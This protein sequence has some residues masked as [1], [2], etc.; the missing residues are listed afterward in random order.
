M[1]FITSNGESRG[2]LARESPVPLTAQETR[3]LKRAERKIAA[4]LK[5]F[6]EVGMAL[7]EIR[8]KRLYRQHYR[9]FEEYVSQRWDI[10]RPRAYE[11]CA[12]SEVIADLSGVPDIPVLPQ[13]EAQ[14]N[15]LARLKT[16]THRKRAWRMALKSASQKS[17]PVTAKDTEEAVNE[18]SDKIDTSPVDGVPVL[19][20]VDGIRAAYADPPYVGQAKK[21]YRCEEVDHRELIERLETY[22]AWAL[23]L[24]S[25]S[26]RQVLPLCPDD[27]RVAAWV[28][29]FAAFKPNVNPAFAWEPV[30]LKLARPRTRHQPTMRDWVSANITLERGL[31]GVKPDDF[32]FWLFEVL[33]L[34]P[35]DQFFDLYEGSGAVTRAFR[36]WLALK[37]EI[38]APNNGGRRGVSS[39]R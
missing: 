30:I 37:R 35:G 11:L 7:K 14:A 1:K 4:G 15:P 21:R 23:S 22:D 36:R 6:L 28:K 19:D 3:D 24:S 2:G 18:L 13:N 12:A 39:R 5:S 32:S 31:C 20:R 10:S 27:V 9:T 25:T 33:N 38:P 26:L 17:R 16:A 29:P 34:R 8:D